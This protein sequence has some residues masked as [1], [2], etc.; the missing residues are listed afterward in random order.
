MCERKMSFQNTLL[1][2]DDRKSPSLPKIYTPDRD[3]ENDETLKKVREGYV[4]PVRKRQL[5]D[6]YM[7]L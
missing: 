6:L 1:R 5:S 7:M 2:E 3:K 4:T